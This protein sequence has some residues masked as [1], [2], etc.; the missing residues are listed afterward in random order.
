MI[1][2]VLGG[3]RSGKSE[4]GE[5]LAAA[6][7]QP[8]T[9]LATADPEGDEDFAARIAAHRARRP[10][11]WRTVECGDDLPGALRSLT[12]PV[13]VDSLGTWVASVAGFAA[14][15]SGLCAAL[16]AHD[17]DV[18]VVSEEVGMGVH[19]STEVGGRFRDSLGS[20]NQAVAAVAGD[21]FLVVAGRALRLESAETAARRSL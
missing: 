15:T 20:A 2:L 14:D 18:I 5:R 9:Y 11:G 17:A 12:G 6:L 13:L 19:P 10:P 3:A 16:T 8:V 21:V 7:P 4:F 1:T